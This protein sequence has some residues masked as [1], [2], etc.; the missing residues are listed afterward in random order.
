MN[1]VF[2]YRLA[3]RGGHE[4]I[5]SDGVDEAHMYV[6]YVSDGLG[7]LV[8]IVVQLL[9]GY[10]YAYCQWEDD[11]GEH[12]WVLRREGEMVRITILRFPS[13]FNGYGAPDEWAEVIFE[14][15]CP[16]VKFAAKVRNEL[17]RL[18]SELGED[19]YQRRAKAPFP[20]DDYNVLR[21]L[22]HEIPAAGS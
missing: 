3:D 14:T 4:A 15:T 21:Q 6:W 11:P 12:K 9:Q 8:R 13:S 17:R 1:L 16:L 19:E 5:I 10:E 2:S 20:M 22:V 18:L 7:E